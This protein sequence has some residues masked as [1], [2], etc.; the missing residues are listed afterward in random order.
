VTFLLDV[1]V[2]VALVLPVH[3]HHHIA[4]RWFEVEAEAEGWAT[5]T[6]SE[7]GAIRICAY[8]EVPPKATADP[9]MV[10]RRTARGH[11]WWTDMMPGRLTEVRAAAG[12]KQVTDR[13][14]PGL[15][16]RRGGRVATLDRGLARSGG[17]D[18][19]CLLP[20]DS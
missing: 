13:Y 15:V 5:C 11:V 2:L 19:I 17:S 20:T 18:V 4:R 12:P 6:V 9:L 14:L 1:N 7:L 16:R 10:L 3:E 8:F